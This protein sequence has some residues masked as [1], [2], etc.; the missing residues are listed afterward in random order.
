[1]RPVSTEVCAVS[2]AWATNEPATVQVASE[3]PPA[4]EEEETSGPGEVSV[5]LRALVWDEPG[6][7]KGSGYTRVHRAMNRATLTLPP[8]A[9]TFGFVDKVGATLGPLAILFF[10][11]PWCSTR[12]LV[13]TLGLGFQLEPFSGADWRQLTGAE[14]AEPAEPAFAPSDTEPAR[15]WTPGEQGGGSGDLG[16]RGSKVSGGDYGGD[17][18]DDEVVV[19]G[20]GERIESASPEA[21]PGV[22]PEASPMAEPAGASQGVESRAQDA[23]LKV[24]AA[25]RTWG[26]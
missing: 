9:L 11:R 7:A 2:H 15:G 24:G 16:L 4:P 26:E 21:S 8:G 10:S 12:A 3:A 23:L 1:M 5:L 18:F 22:S 14:P 25:G 19:G 13:L 6:A 20:D 17:D